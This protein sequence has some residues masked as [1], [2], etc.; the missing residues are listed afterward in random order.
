MFIEIYP[1][2]LGARLGASVPQRVLAFASGDVFVL[3]SDGIYETVDAHGETFGLDRLS[4]IVAACDGTAE[5]IRDAVL[6]DVEEFRG[7]EVQQDD[8]TPVVVRIA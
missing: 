5:E 4:R 1:P 6:R 7:T 2:P 8:V 3:H